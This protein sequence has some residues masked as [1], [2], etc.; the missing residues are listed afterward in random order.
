[1]TKLELR[2][3]ILKVLKVFNGREEAIF[4][5]CWKEIAELK[6]RVDNLFNSDCWASNQLAQAIGI[7]KRWNETNKSAYIEPS[8]ELIETTEQFL[9]E[10]EK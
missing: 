5:I 7:I 2:R 6:K 10:I 3:K 8:Q 9:R 1:M 4:D